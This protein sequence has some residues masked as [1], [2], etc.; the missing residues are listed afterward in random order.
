MV[1]LREYWTDN[2]GALKPGKK[3]ISLNLDQW[4][5]LKKS[6]ES[7]DKAISEL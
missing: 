2:D 1:G 7:I 3:G 4:N 5:I 6:I